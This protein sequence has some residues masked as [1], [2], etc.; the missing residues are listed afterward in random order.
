MTSQEALKQLDQYY[1]SNQL[2][3]AYAFTLECLKVAL[4]TQDILF[5]LEML[6]SLIGHFRVTG[7]VELGKEV[8][9]NILSYIEMYHLEGTKTEA[10]SLLNIATLYK[11]AGMYDQSLELYLKAEGIYKEILEDEDPLFASLYNNFSLLFIE[12]HDYNKALEYAKKAL[13]LAKENEEI[14]SS[15]GNISQI[16]LLL[17]D[18]DLALKC[19]NQA[20]SLF[21]HS[22]RHYIS[23]ISAK[24]LMY[25]KKQEYKKAYDTY[26]IVMERLL[27]VY[28]K[29]DD[30]DTICKNRQMIYDEYLSGLD[31][32]EI[33]YENKVKPL[34]DTKYKDLKL[35]VGL[36]GE[37]SECLGYDDYISKDHDF[38]EGVVILL[39]KENYERYGKSLKEDYEALQSNRNTIANN[40]VGVF[41]ID[42]YLNHYM[43]FLNENDYY[44]YDDYYFLNIT[45]GK[46]FMDSDGTFSKIRSQYQYFPMH[47]YKNKLRMT[48]HD[49]CQMGQYNYIRMK[50]R[51][52]VSSKIILYKFIDACIYM[53]YLLERKYQPYYKWAYYGLKD[54]TLLPDLKEDIKQLIDHPSNELIQKILDDIVECMDKLDLIC[55][56]KQY[57]D[58]I[59]VK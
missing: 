49:L 12:L 30:Y 39:S 42:D 56:K 31:I 7:N 4:D 45:N 10:T 22:S 33:F 27:A 14:A 25:F 20:E 2:E 53:S 55:E 17:D 52:E 26:T 28:G 58:D 29:S 3:K 35:C 50:N 43:P 21:D 6:N 37:G 38:G 19:I 41:C 15:Y 8:A 16:Y 47:I 1:N 46:I 23:T 48:L 18:Y 32:S 5:T 36:F 13:S 9:N 57:L 59:I 34:L 24:A 54:H 51:D 11:V 40:R 44:I